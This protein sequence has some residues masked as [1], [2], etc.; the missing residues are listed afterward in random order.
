MTIKTIYISD[1]DGE[2][3]TSAIE[4]RNWEWKISHLPESIHWYDEEGKLIVPL[5]HNEVARN[6]G[7]IAVVEIL[8]IEGWKE[9]VQ[10]MWTYWGFLDRNMTPGLYKYKTQEDI[11]DWYRSHPDE[12][13]CPFRE[14]W[15]RNENFF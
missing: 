2:E 5:T 15:T 12:E 1:V 14:G 8:D 4:C 3:F 13:T 11:Y 7:K 9:D 6:Y 10:F